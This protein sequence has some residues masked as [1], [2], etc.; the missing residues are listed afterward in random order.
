MS[1]HNHLKFNAI[2]VACQEKVVKGQ[3]VG[4]SG[5]TSESYNP[6][7]H[8]GFGSICNFL[9][10]CKTGTGEIPEQIPAYFQ[11]K[12][13]RAWRPA[14]G[15]KLASNTADRRVAQRA[16][17]AVR[18]YAACRLRPASGRLPSQGSEGA[19]REFPITLTK[20]FTNSD[21]NSTETDCLQAC[22]HS[23]LTKCW[24]QQEQRLGDQRVNRQSGLASE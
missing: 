11:D 7:L 17:S 24:P 16:L 2:K 22:R 15:D 19:C 13:H 3:V 4:L 23:K 21:G 9:N 5:N 8:F 12:N 14:T 18:A 20:Y 6:H 10:D 1:I